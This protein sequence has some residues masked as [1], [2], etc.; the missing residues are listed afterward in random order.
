MKNV[1]SYIPYFVSRYIV[2]FVTVSFV[3]KVKSTV[4]GV[5]FYMLKYN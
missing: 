2:L 4:S 3:I 5:L 1:F